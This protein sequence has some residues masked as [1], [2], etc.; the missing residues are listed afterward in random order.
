MSFASVEFLL[1][2]PLVFFAYF[3]S[4]PPLRRWLL[5]VASYGFYGI[6]HVAYIPL[7]L[8]SSLIDFLC[9]HKMYAATSRRQRKVWL[10]VSLVVNLSTLFLF[11]YSNFIGINLRSVGIDYPLHNLLL[12]IGLSFYTLQT[13]SYTFDVY[14]GKVRPETDVGYFLL[15]VSFFP[16]LVAGPIERPGKLL[17]QL[18]ELKLPTV[19]DFRYGG[20]LIVWGF[21]LKLVIA[22]NL[23]PFV[24]ASYFRETTAPVLQLWSASFLGMVKVYCDFMAYSEIARGTARL[25]GVELTKNFNRPLLA[26]SVRAFWQRWHISLTRWLVDYVQIPLTRKFPHEPQRSLV[27][28]TT[29]VLVGLWHGASWN[30]LLFGLYHGVLMTLWRPA[31]NV[32]QRWLPL[33]PKVRANLGWVNTLIFVSFSTPMFF[34]TDISILFDTL[35]RMLAFD[36]S[37]S[38]VQLIYTSW[39]LD[40][41]FSL[42]ALLMLAIVSWREEYRKREEWQLA[43]I[44]TASVKR[45]TFVLSIMGVTLLL[46]NFSYEPFVYF[47][48]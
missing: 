39:K 36:F 10:G 31:A 29:L 42:P 38:I 40:I 7:L 33:R 9:G 41:V 5:L 14:R 34:I 27:T 15:Y 1:F 17:P 19:Y 48:F 23:T 11:K 43:L 21:F 45:W 30:F 3:I 22:D 8:G 4:P 6:W 35:G 44:D 46:G 16:Q 47:N 26:K 32:C 18:R 25:F 24:S 2:L 13:L 12:P 20:L 37:L 28:I